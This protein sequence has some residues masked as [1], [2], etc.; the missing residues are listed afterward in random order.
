LE[1]I[2][3]IIG[4]CILKPELRNEVYCHVC[5]QL[6]KNPLKDS[7][8]RYWV[9][10]SLLIGSFPPSPWLVPYVQKVLAQSPPIHASVLGKLLQRTLENGVRCQPPSHIE[11]QCALEKRLVELQITFMDGTYQGLVVDA[12]TSSKEIVQ[13]LCDR[14]GLKLSFGFSLYISMSSK[15]AS[16]GSGSD[17]VLDAVSQCEQ[18]FRD[19][20]GEEEKA[21]VRLFFRK[22]LF[23]PWD[24]FSSDL[25]ATNLIFAQVTRGILLNEYSTESVSEGTI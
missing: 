24:D 22:E 20:D 9:F 12:A 13:K 10:I 25:M 3:Y 1:L 14:I 7:A 8:N 21:P 4:H 16:L 19:Q 18:I 17:H 23:S 5:K 2:H 11:V 15:V 6:I